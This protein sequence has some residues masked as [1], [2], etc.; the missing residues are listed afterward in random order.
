MVIERSLVTLDAIN[1]PV[2]FWK[3][4][5]NLTC[6]NELNTTLFYAVPKLKRYSWKPNTQRQEFSPSSICEIVRFVQDTLSD[7]N[8]FSY[9]LPPPYPLLL[10][11]LPLLRLH[12]F[13]S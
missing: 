7:V 5:H 12:H 8:V 4:I 9:F 10:W 1:L 2:R 13:I 3:H 11:Q 6:F